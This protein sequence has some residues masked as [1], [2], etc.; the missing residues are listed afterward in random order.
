MT[1]KSLSYKSA[2]KLTLRGVL[3]KYWQLYLLFIPVAVWY[4]LFSYA[5]MASITIAFKKFSV[6][7]GIADS[8]WV[9][10]EA[11]SRCSPRRCSGARSAIR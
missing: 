11:S 5:P 1:G 2:H 3:T 6:I 7:R 8:P 10:W 4:I 9:G